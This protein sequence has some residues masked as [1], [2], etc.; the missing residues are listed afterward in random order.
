MSNDGK[1]DSVPLVI[2]AVSAALMSSGVP[3]LGPIAAVKIAIQGRQLT[4]NPS[5]EKADSA[6][7]NLLLT[8]NESGI[9]TIRMQVSCKPHSQP[10]S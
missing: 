3:W 6:Q 5:S 10:Q 8:A 7:A 1:T 4:A 2:N 9:V